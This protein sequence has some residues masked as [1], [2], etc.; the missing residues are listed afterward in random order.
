VQSTSEIVQLIFSETDSG[1]IDLAISVST[2]GVNLTLH[3]AANAT[4]QR[5]PARLMRS[6]PSVGVYGVRMRLRPIER[7]GAYPDQ[8]AKLSGIWMSG[9]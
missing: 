5:Q 8:P 1:T 7:H 9:P 3:E 4:I 2:I 6:P